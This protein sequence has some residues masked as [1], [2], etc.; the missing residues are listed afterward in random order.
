MASATSGLAE[1]G[2][3]ARR[4]PR[5]LSLALGQQTLIPRARLS[6]DTPTPGSADWSYL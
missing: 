2:A 5:N 4:R 1:G 3:P 6:T